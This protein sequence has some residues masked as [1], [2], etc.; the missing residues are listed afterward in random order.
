M[1]TMRARITGVERTGLKPCIWVDGPRPV[2][3]DYMDCSS[4]IAPVKIALRELSASRS[5]PLVQLPLRVRLGHITPNLRKRHGETQNNNAN[6]EYFANQGQR[7][8]W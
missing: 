3:A 7:V 1:R 4:A 8:R 5:V 6:S 2:C